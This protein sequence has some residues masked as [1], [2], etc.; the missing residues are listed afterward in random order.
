MIARLMQQNGIVGKTPRRFKRTTI[1]DAAASAVDLA[2]RVFGPGTVEVNRLWCG[3][4]SCIRTWEGWLYLRHRDRRRFP[5]CGRMGDGRSHAHRARDR[6]PQDGSRSTP[7]GTG[8]DLPFRQGCQYTSKEFA[9]LLHDTGSSSRC[10]GPVNVG[11][12]R[13]RRAS[14]QRSVPSSSTGT[15][16]RRAFA[17]AAPSSSS[18]ILGTTSAGCIRHLDTWHRS[19]TK[20]DARDWTS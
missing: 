1:P 6:C 11:I 4:I 7:A 20:G 2:K 15:R 16:G 3:D 9:A 5:S 12:T 17:R 10:P 18:S 14:S 19:T 8:A 13:S